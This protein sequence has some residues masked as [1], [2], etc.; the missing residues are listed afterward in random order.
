MAEAAE[1][2]GLLLV[3]EPLQPKES[4]LVTNLPTA[5]RMLAELDSPSVCCC[6]D[7]VAMAVAGESMVDYFDALGSRLA[8][9][10]L[11]D[12]EPSGHLAWGDGSLPLGDYLDV[13][14]SHG[15][16]AYLTLEPVNVRY[17]RDPDAALRQCVAALRRFLC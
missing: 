1:H 8:H 9:I 14:E 13:L 6:L 10:H 7:T 3:L 12:G 15:Y 2:A 17:I 4:N 11:N 5:R 16:A